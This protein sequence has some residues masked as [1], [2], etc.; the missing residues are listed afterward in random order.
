M[1]SA[2][3]VVLAMRAGTRRKTCAPGAR[4]SAKPHRNESRSTVDARAGAQ[5]WLNPVAR[6]VN[7]SARRQ[8]SMYQQ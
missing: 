2:Q 6:P 1:S 7:P 4:F 3:A 5:S 8:R